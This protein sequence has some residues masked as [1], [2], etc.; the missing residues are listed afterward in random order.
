MET[1]ESHS[2]K[3]P[4]GEKDILPKLNAM[5]SLLPD[6]SAVFAEKIVIKCG[7][8]HIS[9]KEIMQAIAQD[10]ALLRKFGADVVLVHGGGKEVV[11]TIEKFNIAENTTHGHRIIDKEVFGVVEMVLSGK[12][13]PNI[14]SQINNAGARARGMS[15]RD[16]RF[17]TVEKLRRTK[18]DEDSNIERI[19]DLGMVGQPIAM[20]V[21]M[22]LD[23]FDD[24][25]I[26]V[27]SPIGVCKQ[28]KPYIMNADMLAAFIASEIEADRLILLS[29][30]EGI[31]NNKGELQ[32][33]MQP[34][35]AKKILSTTK[36]ESKL[37]LKLESAVAAVAAG[38]TTSYVLNGNTLHA[39]ALQIFGEQKCGTAIIGDATGEIELELE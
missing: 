10:V 18:K 3:H 22:M 7:N 21:D 13:C 1:K 8:D 37:K 14:V 28:G 31:K 5:F 30:F 15:G 19:L 35:D 34:E 16:C 4:K 26:P 23:A 25:I 11:E 9:N 29:D 27:V 32:T 33:E 12:I 24:E 38:V 6:L 17:I 36:L 2:G 20:D 39:V